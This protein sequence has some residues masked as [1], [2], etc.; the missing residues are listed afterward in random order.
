[1]RCTQST[2]CR[3]PPRPDPTMNA[4]VGASGS[5][6]GGFTTLP[7][8]FSPNPRFILPVAMFVLLL[9]GR[10]PRPKAVAP[11]GVGNL[12][13]PPLGNFPP[14]VAPRIPRRH[15]EPARRE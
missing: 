15:G 5:S 8:G 9:W 6:L 14:R 10:T 1:M 7:N 12:P 4:A 11:L 2:A 3:P 13:P